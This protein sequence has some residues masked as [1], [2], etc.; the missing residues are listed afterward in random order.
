M[1]AASVTWSQSYDRELQR[2]IVR[3]ENKNNFYKSKNALVYYLQR[4]RCSY[5][6]KSRRIG[7]IL[8]EFLPFYSLFTYGH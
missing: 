2:H 4:W 3:F 6:F 8:R 5:K 1:I 7:S